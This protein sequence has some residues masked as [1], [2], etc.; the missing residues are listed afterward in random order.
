MQ[1]DVVV[2]TTGAGDALAGALAHRLAQIDD[3]PS[4]LAFAVRVAAVSVTRPGLH[5][6]TRP[7][8]SSRPADTVLNSDFT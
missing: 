5:P 7:R 1:P 8:P 2:D 3:L 6:R 4:A